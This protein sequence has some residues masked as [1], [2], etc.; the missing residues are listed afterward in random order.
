M[1]LKK[2]IETFAKKCAVPKRI[3]LKAGII[4]DLLEQIS[5][6]LSS[7][8]HEELIDFI[9]LKTLH[10]NSITHQEQILSSLK[11]WSNGDLSKMVR[12]VG[13]YF[14]L[15]N[16]AELNEVILINENR[17]KVSEINSPKADGI[18]SAVKYLKENSIRAGE[19]KEMLKSVSIHPTF[20]AHPTETKRQ[21]IISK[22]KKILYYV[23]KILDDD[24]SKK[25]KLKFEN[26][27]LRLCNLIFL[28]D[29]IRAHG[30]SVYDEIN[31]TVKNTITSLW[32]AVP[33]LAEDIE[34]SFVDYYGEKIE[35][36]DFIK[37]HTWVGGDRDGNPNVT[38]EVTKYSI[39]RQVTELVSMYIADLDSLFQEMSI[40][41]KH[42][43][44]NGFLYKSIS[45]DSKTINLKQNLIDRYET[46][47]IRLKILY[48]KEKLTRY[49][50]QINLGEKPNYSSS[51]FGDDLNIIFQYLV[52]DVKNESLAK[53]DLTKLIFRSKIFGLHLFGIDIRQH[54]DIHA[55]VVSEIISYIIPNI[56]YLHLSDSDK[57]S[58]LKKLIHSEKNEFII[59][60]FKCSKPL[61]EI[62]DTFKIIKQALEIDK[63]LISSYIISMTHSK[64]DVLEVL[65][66]G[67]L[68]GLVTCTKGLIVTDLNIV[69]LYETITDLE[70]APKLLFNLFQDELY[71]SY[72]NNKNRFQ[73]IMLGYSDSNKDGGF[74]MANFSLN[75]CQIKISELMIKNNIDF[76]IFHG[77]GGSISRGGGKSNKAIL[78]L[79]DECQNGNIR[80][81]E[82]GEVVNYRYG[83]SQIAKRHLEQIVSAQL[84]VLEKS[85]REDDKSSDNHITQIMLDSQSYYKEKVLSDPCWQFLL[86]ASPMKQISKIPITSR[87][88]SRNKIR[89]DVLGFNELRAIP[90]VFSWTQV[91]YNLSGW[92]G[93]GL[94]LSHALKNPEVLKKLKLMLKESKFFAQLLDNMSFEMARAR[95]DVSGLYAKTKN[96]KNFHKIIRDEFS[97]ALE[98]YKTISG[99]DSLLERNR[100]ISNS[101]DFRNPLTDLLNYAQVELI[102][103]SRN[104]EKEDPELDGAIFSSINN[105]AAAMQTTG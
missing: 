105:I 37:F 44:T 25:E 52:K 48:I 101:I 26:E 45:D 94:A 93:M 13:I 41:H 75:N 21:S 10:P 36:P 73:E 19:A 31:N 46:E 65:F 70:S 82:Q 53:G 29:D 14:H 96:E 90:W 100:I 103:R 2:H 5:I 87:P 12:F 80:F 81:T 35:S 56:D 28:T 85:K 54:S 7:A 38:S 74:G 79:P 33:Q 99:Y 58:L 39:C 49:K 1:I 22:Q 51:L 3:R 20:T 60:N 76:R 40:S 50:Q 86:N 24:F 57:C 64:S 77:R 42:T 69:P 91:R 71:D 15:L 32:E 9:R 11:K 47:P 6:G 61:L 89:D 66:L 4:I 43:N 30:I 8:K 27:A 95:L 83:S 34:S 63:D 17:D 97:L 62:Y 23:E 98:A 102:N 55:K 92:F 88:A 84:V 16:Q 78:S 68:F 59:N 18:A 104:S 72:L 67:K